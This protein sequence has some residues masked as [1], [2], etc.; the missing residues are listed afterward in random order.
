MGNHNVKYL[1]KRIRTN[2]K[3]EHKAQMVVSEAFVYNVKVTHTK[4]C[5][6]VLIT[7]SRLKSRKKV[8]H[9]LAPY[10]FPFYID[11]IPALRPSSRSAIIVGHRHWYVI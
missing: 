11:D 3:S 1:T 2:K 9:T 6:E 10:A 7:G 8:L 4:G 5:S